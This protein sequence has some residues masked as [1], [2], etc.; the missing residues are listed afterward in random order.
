MKHAVIARLF[1]DGRITHK[2]QSGFEYP[3]DK[4]FDTEYYHCIIDV[5][6]SYE[7]ARKFERG[8]RRF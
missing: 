8:Y 7:D 2:V 3:E 5:F 4:E 6:D 1:P